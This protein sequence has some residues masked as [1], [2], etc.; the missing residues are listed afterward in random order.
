MTAAKPSQRAGPGAALVATLAPVIFAVALVTDRAG[1]FGTVLRSPV[2]RSLEE[3]RI[4]VSTVATFQTE[5]EAL[6]F[7]AGIQ[8]METQERERTSADRE[9]LC[10]HGL[11]P[12]TAAEP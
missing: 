6:R 8:G 1:S 11:L 12:V 9:A 3:G 2:P 4:L 10:R 7:L 5:P